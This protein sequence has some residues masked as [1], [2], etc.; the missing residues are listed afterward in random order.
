MWDY[1]RS[2]KDGKKLPQS[3]S[4]SS[5]S[6]DHTLGGW[7]IHM[8]VLYHIQIIYDHGCLSPRETRLDRNQLISNDQPWLQKRLACF[9]AGECLESHALKPI[10]NTDELASPVPFM[11]WGKGQSEII[12]VFK[13][14]WEMKTSRAEREGVS[15]NSYANRMPVKLLIRSSEALTM[16]RHSGV[17]TKSE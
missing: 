9:K 10:S 4:S 8:L 7:R 1:S 12:C 6:C 17:W 2:G 15:G 14:F 16:P 3:I 13:C 5:A 11:G